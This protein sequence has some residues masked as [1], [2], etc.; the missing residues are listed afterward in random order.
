MGKRSTSLDWTS[1]HEYARSLETHTGGMLTIGLLPQPVKYSQAWNVCVALH[2]PV[3]ESPGKP[4]TIV[5][6]GYWPCS[7][8]ATMEGLVY[9]L[10]SLIDAETAR[11]WAQMGL[12]M[13]SA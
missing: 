3:L 5:A 7:D 9:A 8:H 2:C 1:I 12:P 6:D 4:L 11:R 10:L 13:P